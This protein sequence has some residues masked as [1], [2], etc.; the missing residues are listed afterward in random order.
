M[1]LDRRTFLR[2]GAAAAAGLALGG[3][4]FQAYVA[5]AAGVRGRTITPP[6]LV[7]TADLN[8]DNKFRLAVPPGF[9]YRSF[10][11]RGTPMLNGTVPGNH[12]GMAAF[13]RPG[14]SSLLIRNHEINGSRV[15]GAFAGDGPVYD[16]SALGGNTYVLVDADR[17]R[18]QTWGALRG[19]QMNCSGGAM[20]WGSWVTCEETING[21]DVFDDFTR[22][23]SGGTDPGVDT[24]I[25]NA[26][27]TKPHGYLFEVPAD[28]VASAQPITA[29]GRFAHEAAAFDPNTGA[30]YLTEDDFGFGSGFYKYV[31]PVNPRR[32]GRIE[33]GGTLWMLG[34]EGNPGANLSGDQTGASYRTTWI[35]IP[36][37][38]ANMSFPMA[39]G[40]PTVTNNEAIRWVAR[41]GHAGGAA[42]FSRL[43][44]ATYDK[45]VVYFTATQG[46]GVPDPIDWDVSAEPSGFGNG[47]G[48]VWAYDSNKETLTCVYQSTGPQD[49]RLPDN[50]TASARG[51]LVLCED[52]AGPN[53]LQALTKW[54]QLF[55]FAQRL[56]D[57][58]TPLPPAPGGVNEASIEFAGATFSQDGST[59]FFNL[60]TG[61][62]SSVAMWG[63]W[64]SIGI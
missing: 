48:Q 51:T 7:P 47:T 53:R 13:S 1:T 54:G 49:L 60:N 18:V 12:D 62:G 38:D 34:V 17:N 31:P 10:D 46:G 29:A 16:P 57:P 41:A 28:G 61:L 64:Q 9:S 43:E 39:G 27:L 24:Y 5:R 6:T 26:R 25:Q 40:R 11:V 56:D 2:G 19:T 14:R 42:V 55:T 21:P 37:A 45:G 15:G 58:A 59:L 35:P 3:G 33:D 30:L 22:T 4:P 44:G 32:A 23:P 20:P 8:P 36:A 52:N 63:P 50:V